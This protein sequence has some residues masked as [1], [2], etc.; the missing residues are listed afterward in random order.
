MPVLPKRLSAVKH[1]WLLPQV[2]VGFGVTVFTTSLQLRAAD[3]GRKELTPIPHLSM[4]ID[5]NQ[6]RYQRSGGKLHHHEAKDGA[7]SQ[8]RMIR[9]RLTIAASNKIRPDKN[10]LNCLLSI[11]T[12]AR[13][14]W[15]YLTGTKCEDR[16]K[17]SHNKGKNQ[18]INAIPITP[19]FWNH[20][21][22]QHPFPHAFI[23]LFYFKGYE[24]RCGLP[25]PTPNPLASVSI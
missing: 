1:D 14:G 10:S 12:H 8:R 11:K 25:E 23:S 19:K 20:L 18:Q 16:A 2:W 17:A 15:K 24:D 7:L 22:F 9:C 4:T 3:R 21:S 5:G 6:H 13:T